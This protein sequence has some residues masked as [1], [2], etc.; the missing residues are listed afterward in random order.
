MEFGSLFTS[1]P[2]PVR[3]PLYSTTTT[4]FRRRIGWVGLV[5]PHI[6]HMAVGPS[7]SRLLPTAMVLGAGPPSNQKRD[8]ETISSQHSAHRFCCAAMSP[9]HPGP[10]ASYALQ[11]WMS[12]G[13]AAISNGRVFDNQVVCQA[14]NLIDDD[15]F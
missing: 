2:N 11:S 13:S 8:R 10:Q 1:Q 15:Y 3:G 14:V 12:V 5:I 4:T 6:A 7:F 9:R